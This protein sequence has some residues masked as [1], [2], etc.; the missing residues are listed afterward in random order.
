MERRPPTST[1]TDTLFPYTTLFRSRHA[2]LDRDRLVHHSDALPR[3][4]VDAREDWVEAGASHAN[5]AGGVAVARRVMAP[6]P[7]RI[8]NLE[9]DIAAP[10]EPGPVFRGAPGLVH[11]VGASGIRGTPGRGIVHAAPGGR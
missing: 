10:S 2:G 4:S 7:G 5:R 11:Q 9:G 6:S 3:V 1:R 8:H